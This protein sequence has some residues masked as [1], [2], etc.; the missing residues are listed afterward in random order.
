[1]IPA[2]P[3][4]QSFSTS[5]LERNASKLGY[6]KPPLPSSAQTV[7]KL[8]GFEVRQHG[9]SRGKLWTGGKPNTQSKHYLF[10]DA[11]AT[12]SLSLRKEGYSMNKVNAVASGGKKKQ[13]HNP[14]QGERRWV[15]EKCLVAKSI[16]EWL[17]MNSCEKPLQFSKWI[18]PNMQ[19]YC[20][21]LLSCKQL[22]QY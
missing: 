2:C 11:A 18:P 7:Y 17:L 3:I 14:Q 20:M 1:M 15:D 8:H 12:F 5:T 22:F 19:V 10:S 13:I 16:L 4:S 21:L 6:P 9:E